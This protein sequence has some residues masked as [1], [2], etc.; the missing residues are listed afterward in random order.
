MK[1]SRQLL[2][3]CTGFAIVWSLVLAY[4]LLIAGAAFGPSGGTPPV[5]T[6]WF[7]SWLSLPLTAV[8]WFS[9]GMVVFWRKNERRVWRRSGFNDDVYDLMVRMRGAGSRLVLL[10]YLDAPRHRMELS[11][12]SGLDWK[13]VDRET[14]L[15]ERY[16]LI[17]VYAES[18]SVKIYSLTEQGRLLLKL[19]DE[20]S[21][22]R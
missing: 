12:L 19:T 21:R 9:T 20:L 18:G 4:S 10:K 3:F 5:G 17:A 8:G 13:E 11:Q 15:L 7:V 1:P 16:G 22:R 6:L 14:G 2:V